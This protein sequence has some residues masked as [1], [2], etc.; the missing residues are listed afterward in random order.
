MTK[1]ILNQEE[2][3]FVLKNYK[4]ISTQELVDMLNKK[5]NRSFSFNQIRWYKK[6]RKLNSGINFRFKKGCIPHNKKKIG[7]EFIHEL[8]GY[9]FVKVGEPRQWVQK[10]RY[11]YEQYY[12]KIPKGYNVIFADGNKKNFDID[13]L[14]LVTE[15]EF[16]AMLDYKLFFK[17]DELTKTGLLIAKLKNK[18]KKVGE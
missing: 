3:D 11:V 14:M 1:S 16:R 7:D 8:T 2:K 15:K 9:T 4:G 18:T 10:Q 13:N 17:N 12:G 5:F 6:A